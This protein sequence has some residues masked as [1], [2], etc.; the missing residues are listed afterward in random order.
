MFTFHIEQVTIYWEDEL[1]VMERSHVLSEDSCPT[2]LA[3][4][5]EDDSVH[6]VE[7]KRL[8]MVL[9][10]IEQDRISTVLQAAGSYYYDGKI[11]ESTGILL[12]I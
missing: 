7:M 5:P 9:N 2:N 8:L 1:V 12:E 6:W 11:K 4:Q 10:N 3:I